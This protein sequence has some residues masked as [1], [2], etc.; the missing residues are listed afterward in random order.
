MVLINLRTHMQKYSLFIPAIAI[1]LC[2]LSACGTS[3]NAEM[4]K[5]YQRMVEKQQLRREAIEAD[6][7]QNKPSPA[8]DP[9]ASE[10]MGDNYL[11]AGNLPMAHLEYSKA[12]KADPNRVEVRQ[13]LAY[14]LLK[15]Q[16]WSEALDEF[17]TILEKSPGDPGSMQGKATA[18][19]HLNRLGEA[20]EILELLINN[21]SSLWQAH[22]LLGTIYDRQKM[23]K[24]SIDEYEKAL[25][26]NPKA[27]GLYEK[28]G[29]SLYMAGDYKQ[30]AAV[31]LKAINQNGSNTNLYTSLGFAL[32]KLGLIDEAY[33][34]FRKAGDEATACNNMGKMYL[35]AKDYP[36]SIEYFEK[37]IDLKPSYYEAANHGLTK[38]R[39]ALNGST[40]S[41]PSSV[42]PAKAGVK[43]KLLPR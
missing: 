13:K 29:R 28:L 4:D 9:L 17:D 8:T 32:F 21:D 11:R 34:T 3:R 40:D 23:Y 39:T 37:A 15:Q 36:K 2:S 7:F 27:A 10:Q 24:L 42:A 6:E 5:Q 16:M 12:L 20:R 25:A 18:L 43:E 38:A 14:L 41:T 19:M 30:S 1:L 22:A 26:I 33:E 35:E 31:L